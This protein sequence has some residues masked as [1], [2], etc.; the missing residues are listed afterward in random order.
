MGTSATVGDE[1]AEVVA[2]EFGFLLD[3]GFRCTVETPSSV[4]YEGP[5]DEVILDEAMSLRRRYTERYIKP[6]S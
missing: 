6:P 4:L 3:R 5:D 1:F 2:S